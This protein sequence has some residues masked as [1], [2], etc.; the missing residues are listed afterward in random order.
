MARYVRFRANDGN[1][2]WWRIIS[3]HYGGG[4]MAEYIFSTRPSMRFHHK[5]R[6]THI[7]SAGQY[8]S[9]GTRTDFDDA[10][11][12]PDELL[13]QMARDALLNG[14]NE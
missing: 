9:Y 3:A 13:V 14:L 2:T 8:A 11:D 6:K 4:D 10:D 7:V 12:L 1:E 5:G